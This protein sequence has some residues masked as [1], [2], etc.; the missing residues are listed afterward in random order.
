MGYAQ[1]QL[2]NHRTPTLGICKVQEP[3]MSGTRRD[4]ALQL[5]SL[6]RLDPSPTRGWGFVA[7][8]RPGYSGTAG[9]PSSF[10]GAGTC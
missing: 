9:S 5:P 4:D 10:L 6:L 8:G 1:Y 3:G 2:L 7:V